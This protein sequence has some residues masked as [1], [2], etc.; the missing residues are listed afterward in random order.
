MP[1]KLTVWCDFLQLQKYFLCACLIPSCY[2]G[3]SAYLD[4]TSYIQ[5]LV[6]ADR[7]VSEKDKSKRQVCLFII[8]IWEL[9]IETQT[10]IFFNEKN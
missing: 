5:R 6:N 8:S 2:L 1:S 4:K 7:S 10:V 9:D 3:I